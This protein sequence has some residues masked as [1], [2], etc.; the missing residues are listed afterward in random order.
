M[1]MRP[2]ILNWKS[3]VVA[4]AA[5]LAAGCQ[6]PNSAERVN[7]PINVVFGSG[8]AVDAIDTSC[9]ETSLPE[10][11]RFHFVDVPGEALMESGRDLTPA[12]LKDIS[13]FLSDL[14]SGGGGRRADRTLVYLDPFTNVLPYEGDADVLGSQLDTNGGAGPLSGV[15]LLPKTTI[16]I[17]FTAWTRP[18]LSPGVYSKTPELCIGETT[19][20]V[21]DGTTVTIVATKAETVSLPVQ[22]TDQYN[23]GYSFNYGGTMIDFAHI[24]L[25]DQD[26]GYGFPPVNNSD[27][28]NLDFSATFSGLN[29]TYTFPEVPTGREYKFVAWYPGRHPTGFNFNYG[30]NAGFQSNVDLAGMYGV[31]APCTVGT[32]C[33]APVTVDID[34][35][36]EQPMGLVNFPVGFVA[37]DA[38]TKSPDNSGILD[39]LKSVSLCH[40]TGYVGNVG[41]GDNADDYDCAT[42]VES[43]VPLPPAPEMAFVGVSSPYD[44]DINAGFGP[45][46]NGNFV[47]NPISFGGINFTLTQGFA[48]VPMPDPDRSSGRGLDTGVIQPDFG[49]GYGSSYC[50]WADF[51]GS[52]AAITRAVDSKIDTGSAE[53]S[54][55]ALQKLN[56]SAL[57]NGICQTGPRADLPSPRPDLSEGVTLEVKRLEAAPSSTT[58]SIPFGCSPSAVDFTVTGLATGSVVV[59]PEPAAGDRPDFNYTIDNCTVVGGLASCISVDTCYWVGT[60]GK[61]RA[62]TVGTDMVPSSDFLEISVTGDGVSDCG[63]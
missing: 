6:S 7:V 45:T 37:K 2:V 42:G 23:T 56:G 1:R 17:E 34:F 27:D 63:C 18:R 36:Q 44:F 43:D 39:S 61:L 9:T 8:A 21:G 12:Q 22:V 38:V 16:R 19:V 13:G 52:P 51:F 25:V 57:N 59:V 10:Y 49:T 60:G 53:A 55:V 35:T 32:D 50:L 31:S 58:S 54:V 41:F 62:Y 4:S 47:N 26:T 30:F 11:M 46:P 20:D 24:S 29:S 28:D 14:P 48:G 33:P 15:Y 5:L 3:F 40:L